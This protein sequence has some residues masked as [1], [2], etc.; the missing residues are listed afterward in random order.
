M[1]QNYTV[2]VENNAYPVV[3]SDER[4]ALL[5]AKAVGSV[6]CCVINRKSGKQETLLGRR[7]SRCPG[8]HLPRILRAQSCAV[9][10]ASHGSQPRPT[11]CINR[12]IYSGWT[13]GADARRTRNVW[14]TEEERTA[15]RVFYD[16]DKLESY[17]K[18][19]YHFF[20]STGI[21]AGGSRKADDVIVGKGRGDESGRIEHGEFRP[22]QNNTNRRAICR[23]SGARRTTSLRPLTAAKD[24]QKEACRAILNYAKEE[25]ACRYAPGWQQ[26][27][28]GIHPV[29]WRN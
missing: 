24:M 21:W 22:T 9:T 18:S 2:W 16:K 12:E 7:V 10:S 20:M 25:L 3:V 26:K 27:N 11:V 6:F 14:Y 15:D 1:V 5:A 28:T 13:S 8:C 4:E 29:C 19:Q 17:I 23:I